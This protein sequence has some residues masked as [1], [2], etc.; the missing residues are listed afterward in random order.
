MTKKKMSRLWTRLFAWFEWIKFRRVKNDKIIFSGVT[1]Y[2][3]D[4]DR[5]EQDG[6]PS[7]VYQMDLILIHRHKNRGVWPHAV[8]FVMMQMRKSARIWGN[9]FVLIG[10]KNSK[11]WESNFF[12]SPYLKKMGKAHLPSLIS[13]IKLCLAKTQITRYQS[14]SDYPYRIE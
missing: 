11:N 3:K 8:E 6:V 5:R 9:K 10:N 13:A 12:Y 4:V 2:V 14:Q 7:E 1:A